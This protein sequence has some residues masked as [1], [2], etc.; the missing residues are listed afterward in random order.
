MSLDYDQRK[1]KGV[2]LFSA[3]SPR[4]VSLLL[5]NDIKEIL[6]SH[7]YIKKRKDAFQEELLPEIKNRGGIFMVDSGGHSFIDMFFRGT[8]TAEMYKVNYWTKYIEEY[9]QWLHDYKDYI[10]IAANV[11]LEF[12]VGNDVVDRWNH[13]YFKPLEKYMEIS[14]VAHEDRTGK[15][16]DKTGLKRIKQY[17]EEHKYVGISGTRSMIKQ[18]VKIYELNKIHRKRLHGFGWTSIPRL[19]SCPFFSVDSTTWIGGAKY[20]TSY[21][22]DGKNFRVMDNNH[23]YLRKNDKQKVKDAGLDFDDLIYEE[24]QDTVNAYNLIGWKGA[25]QEYLRAAN[26]KLPNLS[27][28]HYFKK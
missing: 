9:V 15:F 4:D 21:R 19:K 22:Y 7:Y 26:M 5:D 24:K 23:K 6:V 3:S 11:D 20:G 25:R 1:N 28:S 18:G 10:D 14:Y 8:E 16:N 17:L 27:V 2:M 13:K 12:Y